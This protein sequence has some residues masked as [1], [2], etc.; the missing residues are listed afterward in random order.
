MLKRLLHGSPVAVHNHGNGNGNVV[1]L[2]Y[3]NT[4]STFV[5]GLLLAGACGASTQDGWAKSE[6]SF[7]EELAEKTLTQGF[8]AIA[9]RT[10]DKVTVSNIAMEGLH[11][12]GTI[13]PT[14]T[15]QRVD[16]TVRLSATE[17][18]AA[19]YPA[20][21]DD[22]VRGWS[23]LTVTIATEAGHLSPAL[24]KANMEQVLEAVF[25]ATLS[26]LDLF[27]RYHGAAEARRLRAERNGFGG[28]GITF[29]HE[30]RGL[31]IR[32]VLDQSPASYAGIKSG[33][34]ILRIDGLDV[35]SLDHASIVEHLRGAVGSDLDLVV[36]D[37]DGQHIQRTLRRSLIVP[38][39]VTSSTHEG[40][41]SLHVSS[42]N[43]KTAES[44]TS[45]L[46]RSKDQLGPMLKGVILDLR[47]NP[48]GLLDQ[49]VM[50]ADLFIPSGIIV[51][52][53][54]RHP[55]SNQSYDA[56]E[57][58]VGEGLPV[59][60]LVDGKSASA[61]EILAGALEDSGRAIVIGTNSYGKGTV[62]TVVHLP[63]DG[64][65]TLTWSRFF[66]P[67]GYALHGLGVLPTLCTAQTD[68]AP[69]APQDYISLASTIPHDLAEWRRVRVDDSTSRAQLRGLCPASARS[70]KDSDVVLAEKILSQPTLYQRA[71]SLSTPPSKSFAEG[72]R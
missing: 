41:L 10:L 13:D 50:A 15:V 34:L 60:V 55:L 37:A 51:Q 36:A 9:E 23:R 45:E 18:I 21:A 25:D 43:Q 5:I 39:T 7:D 70:D 64:E 12:L 30:A 56:A 68:S 26:R 49:A 38:P 33:S 27:S 8:S 69:I 63:N 24:K 40:V 58:A 65:I 3:K 46:V 72:P 35:L 54:G 52:T 32:T 57:G 44:I 22:D 42:F 14:L 48:G 31:R 71:L 53:R 2:S 4:L 29:D 66:T 61:A 28:I 20:P 47:G 11:G 1:V 62:Q 16:D 59:V 6:V 67:S 19:E 17:R